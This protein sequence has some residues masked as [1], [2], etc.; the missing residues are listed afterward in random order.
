[1]GWLLFEDIV[2]KITNIQQLKTMFLLGVRIFDRIQFL[3]KFVVRTSIELKVTIKCQINYNPF[4]TILRDGGIDEEIGLSLEMMIDTTRFVPWIVDKFF[5]FHNN[6]PFCKRARK[7]LRELNMSLTAIL[8]Q[9]IWGL[10]RC[11]TCEIWR[12]MC[13]T[14]TH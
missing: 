5:F 2:I 12:V 4:S 3:K 9:S 6:S 8:W 14:L 13:F 10:S 1:M 7:N 11:C